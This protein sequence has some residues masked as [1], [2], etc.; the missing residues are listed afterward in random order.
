[1]DVLQA[2]DIFILDT[3]ELEREL[4]RIT[5][6]YDGSLSEIAEL[7]QKELDERKGSEAIISALSGNGDFSQKSYSQ[8]TFEQIVPKSEPEIDFKNDDCDTDLYNI[9]PESTAQ[10]RYEKIAMNSR[11]SKSR[12]SSSNSR[13]AR[14]SEN[15]D[16]NVTYDFTIGSSG[17]VKKKKPQKQEDI[18]STTPVEDMRKRS[19]SDSSL[20]RS[21]SANR[22]IVNQDSTQSKSTTPTPVITPRKPPVPRRPIK[23][24]RS[25]SKKDQSP[26]MMAS[27]SPETVVTE[28][29]IEQ[30]LIS[31]VCDVEEQLPSTVEETVAGDVIVVNK[32]G[33]EQIE[34]AGV[35]TSEAIQTEANESQVAQETE[36][37]KEEAPLVVEDAT[38]TCSS[39]DDSCTD[40]VADLTPGI[41]SKD[42][43]TR[44]T[45][46][47]GTCDDIQEEITAV[48]D[49]VIVQQE[50]INQG[51]TSQDDLDDV[52]DDDQTISDDS[53]SIN[54]DEPITINILPTT[55]NDPAP[56]YPKEELPTTPIIQDI[57]SSDDDEPNYRISDRTYSKNKK[58]EKKDRERNQRRESLKQREYAVVS[59]AKGKTAE[60]NP[61]VLKQY[62]DTVK[63]TY[64]EAFKRPSD[65]SKSKKQNNALT[66]LAPSPFEIV[67]EKLDYSSMYTCFA[68][69]FPGCNGKDLSTIMDDVATSLE[70]WNIKV[71]G[72]HINSHCNFY[73]VQQ[74]R[75]E[76]YDI[77]KNAMRE[78]GPHKWQQQPAQQNMW[79]LLWMWTTKLRVERSKLLVWQHLNHFS[80]VKQLT[81][82]DLLGKHVTRLQRLPGRKGQEFDLVPSTFV[83][84]QDYVAFCSAFETSPF[85]IMKPV[86]SSR[87]RGIRVIDDITDVHYRDHV[88]IQKYIDRPLLLRGYKFDLR[89]YVLVTSFQPL[90]AFLYSE[91]FA[92]ICS[93]KFKLSKETITNTQMHL[94]NT[95]VNQGQGN[96]GHDG[97][98]KV[99][100]ET[101]KYQLKTLTNADFDRDIWP[102][103]SEL[104]VKSL[105]CVEEH[106][107]SQPNSFEL[108]GYDV[109]IDE[110]FRPWLIEVNASPSM[111]CYSSIDDIKRDMITDTIQ[112]IDP[113]YFDRQV[114]LNVI[115]RRY[116]SNGSRH[117]QTSKAQMQDELNQDLT[118]ILHGKMP[119]QYGQMPERMGRYQRIAPSKIYSKVNKLKHM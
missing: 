13:I 68:D 25:E 39:V 11:R 34:S 27:I 58:Q 19:R 61:K 95:A 107:G 30:E 7:I 55:N 86:S 8:H 48:Q 46:I 82:K 84:P 85:W 78:I 102:A 23:V 113:V 70:L 115:Q 1:M 93:E 104:I 67:S 119:R 32:A 73:A 64:E 92:R 97:T 5:S 105:C 99:S 76:V 90:E 60:C 118:K 16:P 38:N 22:P 111:E 80:N 106:I 96:E 36:N 14:D 91:G 42:E 15:T 37:V 9:T 17:P 110:N 43:E 51:S 88:I 44:D 31:F 62:L 103:I 29:P 3:D 35:E 59:L 52:D 45:I 21:S 33:S 77:V 54:S 56:P 50:N 71:G 24:N 10:E 2:E 83:L 75:Q 69:L 100:L 72:V 49:P 114:L 74:S 108:F 112:L 65:S 101:L 57:S 79:S 12:A 109:L 81:R 98:S 47:A 87:G 40:F 18:K 6:C 20:K 28:E 4:E 41:A 66:L 53:T 89:L 26:T 116:K 117:Q 94:T 63:E